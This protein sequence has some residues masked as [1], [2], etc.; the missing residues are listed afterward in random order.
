MKPPARN[1]TVA[2]TFAL[3]P[4]TSHLPF[5]LAAT[6]ADDLARHLDLARR[7]LPECP[8]ADILRA[9][10]A[11]LLR[12]CERP[13]VVAVEDWRSSSA[14]LGDD[15]A[16]GS[17]P[18]P[19]DVVAA[20]MPSTDLGGSSQARESPPEMVRGDGASRTPRAIDAWWFADAV[21]VVASA[22]EERTRREN[23]A[24]NTSDKS[25]DVSKGPFP[26]QKPDHGT[27]DG[28]RLDAWTQHPPPMDADASQRGARRLWRS[29]KTFAK[30]PLAEDSLAAAA[31]AA[32]QLGPLGS[33]SAFVIVQ[34]CESAREA[35]DA[36]GCLVRAGLAEARVFCLEKSLDEEV[37]LGG[38]GDDGG[39]AASFREWR[40]AWGRDRAR[41]VARDYAP[42]RDCVRFWGSFGTVED[43]GG[44]GGGEALKEAASASES[45]SMEDRVDAAARAARAALEAAH[46]EASLASLGSFL[47]TALEGLPRL[48]VG[49]AFD[50]A[51]KHRGSDRAAVATA[52]YGS[53]AFE[54]AAGFFLSWTVPG[55][56]AAH[57]AHFTNRFRT[58]F[59]CALLAGESPLDPRVV[60]AALAVCAGADGSLAL[61]ATL[62]TSER[63]VEVRRREERARAAA[64]E[65]RERK[66]SAAAAGAASGGGET[67]TGVERELAGARMDAAV[68]KSLVDSTSELRRRAMRAMRSVTD[69]G[70][71]ALREAE[72]A[73]VDA[74]RVVGDSARAKRSETAA[75]TVE[76]KPGE[77][78]DIAE[79]TF[80]LALARETA[81]RVA[82]LVCGPMWLGATQADFTSMAAGAMSVYACNQSMSLFLPGSSCRGESAE[83][84]AARRALTPSDG[85][86]ELSLDVDLDDD[87]DENFG[88]DETPAAPLRRR[89]LRVRVT[90]R[91][92]P[93]AGG[94][95]G[96]V[97]RLTNETRKGLDAAGRSITSVGVAVGH[98]TMDGARA[99]GRA[100]GE[101][102]KNIA[103]AGEWIG[104]SVTSVASNLA[105][106]GSG[107]A[108]GEA[109]HRVAGEPGA[110]GA[111]AAGSSPSPSSSSSSFFAGIGAAARSPFAPSSSNRSTQP[112]APNRSS[113]A[114][115]SSFDGPPIV[116]DVSSLT[117]AQV[118]AVISD[119]AVNAAIGKPSMVMKIMSDRKVVA[120][121]RD[122]RVT[123]AYMEFTREPCMFVKYKD[124]ERV[125]ALAQRVLELIAESGD[126][127]L[128]EVMDRHDLFQPPPPD[129][130]AMD[131]REKSAEYDAIAAKYGGGAPGGNGSPPRTNE[132]GGWL[133]GLKMPTVTMPVIPAMG[134]PSVK[135][136]IPSF[137][138]AAETTGGGAT[139]AAA[140]TKKGLTNVATGEASEE[141]DSDSDEF[142]DAES[143]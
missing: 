42:V 108:H 99:A 6:L 107:R 11:S 29:D 51:R 125:L 3:T 56:L 68:C 23:L 15:E 85:A 128:I 103:G 39:M 123:K 114:S 32:S 41:R 130:M 25:N 72:A 19:D 49:G 40:A 47:R 138:P 124:D 10:L 142:L 62:E 12:A 71:D 4:P 28:S 37:R 13:P 92:V 93:V 1:T 112:N 143:D 137:G 86:V 74:A 27:R 82:V 36:R 54:Y 139:P 115:S 87:D 60:A 84:A 95:M 69:A 57:A 140:T 58:A 91:P 38:G 136:K 134:L 98:A 21:V 75:K 102:G 77:V 48:G 14:R 101:V 55:P 46:A 65:E 64:E 35:R 80:G 63:R 73:A 70:V 61:D 81:R 59:V 22:A 17:A 34:D 33:D 26:E 119:P 133:G 67:K 79:R 96:E 111:E 100:I 43:D 131:P 52:L 9:R 2:P 141:D 116:K 76:L 16:S 105:S 110:R 97:N 135:V 120:S 66:Q 7:V 78:E 88:A 109:E 83:D 24:D 18:A 20:L 132:S 89:A 121:L 117:P 129:A 90:L 104:A 50:V 106:S 113:C 5:P 53:S 8:H 94:V 127:A 122:P 31:T 30:S 118:E 44:D 126:E 45:D